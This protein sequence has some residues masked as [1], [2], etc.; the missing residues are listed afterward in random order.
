MRVYI[1]AYAYVRVCAFVY[2]DLVPCLSYQ[3]REN[4]SARELDVAGDEPEAQLRVASTCLNDFTT[5]RAAPKC[6][7]A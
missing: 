2:V 5:L 1:C 4:N 6:V 7:R 3:T